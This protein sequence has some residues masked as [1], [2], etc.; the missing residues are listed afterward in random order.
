VYREGVFPLTQTTSANTFGDNFHGRVVCLRIVGERNRIGVRMFGEP[1]GGN[2]C[3]TFAGQVE[4]GRQPSHG[5]T[6]PR[7]PSRR[8]AVTLVRHDLPC[9]VAARNLP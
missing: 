3:T 4:T 8:Q 9:C 2:V 5:Q 1:L 6:A 7:L